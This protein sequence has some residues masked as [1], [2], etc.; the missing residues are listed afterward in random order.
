MGHPFVNYCLDCD[1]SASTEQHTRQDL[2]SR[3]IEHACSTG[4]DVEGRRPRSDRDEPGT[5][6]HR[7]RNTVATEHDRHEPTRTYGDRQRVYRVSD[8]YRAGTAG[9]DDSDDGRS[10]DGRSDGGEHADGSETDGGDGDI[11][12]RTDGPGRPD[13]SDGFTREDFE[14]DLRRLVRRAYRV[15]IPIEGCDARSPERAIPDYTIDISELSKR[16]VDTEPALRNGE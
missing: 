9:T 12:R 3:T 1:W 8:G 16:P 13:A 2:S 5:D 10:V 7:E 15:G 6:G 14:A 4:H 11:S